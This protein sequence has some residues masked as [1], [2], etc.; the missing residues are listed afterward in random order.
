MN[1]NPKL[2]SEDLIS[3]LQTVSGS[4]G[5]RLEWIEFK[6]C[7]LVSPVTTDLLDV[8]T[9]KLNHHF[10]CQRLELTCQG[11]NKSDTDALAEVW[12]HRWGVASEI[13]VTGQTLIL[14]SKE[15]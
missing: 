12:R 13:S 4:S 14:S 10:P 1:N 15:S 2:H 7:G 3:I 5:H 8:L 6:H 11:L 9:D